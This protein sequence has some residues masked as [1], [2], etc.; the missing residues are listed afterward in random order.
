MPKVFAR[1]KCR[2]CDDAPLATLPFEH[3][4]NF[5]GKVVDVKNKYIR[6]ID[7]ID[8]MRD[9]ILKVGD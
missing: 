2:E 1:Y 7:A 3:Y 6:M 4:Y 5:G 9:Y 8:R